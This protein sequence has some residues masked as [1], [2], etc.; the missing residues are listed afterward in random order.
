M[1]S[2]ATYAKRRPGRLW[3][4]GIATFAFCATSGDLS[5]AQGSDDILVHAVHLSE[6]TTWCPASEGVPTRVTIYGPDVFIGTGGAAARVAVRRGTDGR[7]YVDVSRVDVDQFRIGRGVDR[8]PQQRLSPRAGELQLAGR[9]RARAEVCLSTYGAR[10]HAADWDV[11][12]PDGDPAFSGETHWTELSSL[13]NT[14]G[15]FPKSIVL[16]RQTFV[17]EEPTII[18]TTEAFASPAEEQS[19]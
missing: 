11:T 15:R 7:E 10:S 6:S 13:M 2:K 3:P 5:M 16:V 19:R 4:V 8:V 9:L 1:W 14:H 17:I 12:T 18:R